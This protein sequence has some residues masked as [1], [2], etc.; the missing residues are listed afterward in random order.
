MRRAST[1]LRALRAE[2]AALRTVV[3]TVTATLEGVAAG[4]LERRTP[5]LP[6][7]PGVATDRLRVA[8]N[9]L[10]DV[11][12]GFLREASSALAAAAAGRHER[13]ILLRGLPG[14]FRRSA[15]VIDEASA[16][17]ARRDEQIATAAQERNA[18]AGDFERDVLSGTKHV[19]GT[20]VTMTQTVAG[21]GG[22]VATLEADTTQGA[23][24]VA[25][26]TESS[27]VIAQV[28]KLI[29]DVAAQTRLLALNATIEAARAGDAG[30][31]FAVVADEVKRLSD[32]TAQASARVEENLD[33]S[34]LAI[35][36]VARALGQIEQSVGTMR[37]DVDQLDES[38]AGAGAD[39]L[40]GTAAS[41]DHHVRLFLAELQR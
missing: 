26:L 11:T 41:L 8:L 14:A 3:D 15:Q 33:R 5:E 24:A 21:L 20:T 39:S 7:V 28:I 40:A 9:A 18:L 31:S 12:D 25:R 38:T 10:V 23:A 6:E 36:E 22:T 19:H 4:D 16:S 35:E 1:E 13:R 29:T 27:A 30:R 32:Q 17:I 2:N 37:T 34:R